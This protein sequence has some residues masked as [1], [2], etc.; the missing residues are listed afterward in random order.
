V[1]HCTVWFERGYDMLFSKGGQFERDTFFKGVTSKRTYY[2]CFLIRT[3][4]LIT[5][6]KFC[7]AN[8]KCTSS[9]ISVNEIAWEIYAILW[10]TV[11]IF[12]VKYSP[13]CSWGRTSKI[14]GEKKYVQIFM[15]IWVQYTTF[16]SR[17][18]LPGG[19]F[20]PSNIPSNVFDFLFDISTQNIGGCFR[21]FKRWH[22]S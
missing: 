1:S 7:S 2:Y 21:T 11:S 16:T 8:A 19:L 14:C 3:P 4:P 18:Q 20:I 9:V 22:F 6:A 5:V 13:C 12:S 10:M 17:S 15:T